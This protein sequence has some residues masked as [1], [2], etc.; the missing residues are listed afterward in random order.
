MIKKYYLII[1]LKFIIES[2]ILSYSLIGYIYILELS[3]V[4]VGI[5]IYNKFSLDLYKL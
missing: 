1:K 3:Q 5:Y 2:I 4:K